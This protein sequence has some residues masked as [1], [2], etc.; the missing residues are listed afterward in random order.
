ML[1]PDNDPPP[2]PDRRDGTGRVALWF[3]LAGLAALPVTM[4]IA[5]PRSP[6]LLVLLPL[7]LALLAAG[8]IV[9]MRAP[10]GLAGWAALWVSFAGI[11]AYLMC[12]PILFA[13]DEYHGSKTLNNIRQL[14]VAVQMYSQDNGD[15]YPGWVNNGTKAS[16]RYVHNV[17]DQ[18]IDH[19]VKR[20]DV[21]TNG[22]AGIRSPSQPGPH[23]NRVLTYGLN[24]ILITGWHG[25]HTGFTAFDKR[26]PPAPL[27]PSSISNPSG[28]IL[29]AELA[30]DAP[31]DGVYGQP[32]PPDQRPKSGGTDWAGT[33]DY[34]RARPGWIDIDPRAFCELAYP[35]AN[36]YQEPYDGATGRGVA[37]NL[38]GGVG[39]YAFCDGHVQGMRIAKTV[40]IGQTVNGKLVTADNCWEPWNTLNMWNPL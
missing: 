34:E 32:I 24:G 25:G 21:F 20:A 13:R 2:A 1:Q 17:W 11:V 16:P 7:G 12:L 27:G 40:G 14:A 6:L 23:R 15:T 9:A 26:N 36:N 3:A 30:T 18:Q 22:Y 28:T 35:L 8:A 19:R 31:M 37:R 10:R 38:Y 33:R 39:C 29:F 4:A 5:P